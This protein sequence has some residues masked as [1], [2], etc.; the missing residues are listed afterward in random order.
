MIRIIILILCSIFSLRA[1]VPNFDVRGNW[2]GELKVGATLELIFKVRGL[3]NIEGSLDVP[4]QGAKDIP[5]LIN[6]T[7]QSVK[8]QVQA[9]NGLF[10][11]K[12]IDSITLEGNWK[13]NGGIYPLKLVKKEGN[14]EPPKRP[15]TPKGPFP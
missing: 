12:K 6:E 1:Q 14:F 5:M 13:Q 11:G 9:I 10:D 2:V 8:F 7:Q 4:L 3:Y 15:Q